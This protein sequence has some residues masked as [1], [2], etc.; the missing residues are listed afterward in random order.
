[1]KIC[2]TTDLLTGRDLGIEVIET[3]LEVFD[4][5]SLLA[6]SFKEGAILGPVELR[7]ITSTSLTHKIHNYHDLQKYSFLAPGVLGNHFISCQYDLIINVSRGLSHGFKRCKTTRQITYLLDQAANPTGKNFIEKL[8]KSFVNKWA[9]RKL[10]QVDE[11]WVSSVAM[12]EQLKGFYSKEII[13]VPPFIKVQDFPL[14]PS[15][16]YPHNY[17][18]INAE[19]IDLKLAESLIS[20][21]KAQKFEFRFVGKDTHLQ[22]L[23]KNHKEHIFLGEKCNGD[24]APILAASR[25][26]IDLNKSTFPALSLCA[27]SSGRPVIIS[28]NDYIS[29]EGVFTIG[30]DKKE[31]ILEQ[32]E[33]LNNKHPEIGPEKLHGQANNFHQMKFKGLIQRRIERG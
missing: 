7:N 18:V 23:K 5:A 2:I 16:V 32:I 14:I 11:L 19:V 8:F 22:S 28:Q 21:M 24:L 6:I 4:Q 20:I 13:V 27:L 10:D 29:G 3:F 25:G 26:L 17:Y 12:K 9:L 15:D 1:M 30:D 31:T 33:A